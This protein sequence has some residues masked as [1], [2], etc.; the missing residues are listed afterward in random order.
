MFRV[1]LSHGRATV[2]VV[3]VLAADAIGADAVMLVLVVVDVF[4]VAGALVVVLVLVVGVVV[5]NGAVDAVLVGV[6][7]HAVVYV[8]V[9]VVPEVVFVVV[10]L[11]RVV[12][13]RG[14]TVVGVVVLLVH[15]LIVPT[16]GC[17]LD[18]LKVRGPVLAGYLR[19]L[20][21]PRRCNGC[22]ARRPRCPFTWQPFRVELVVGVVV[23]VQLVRVPLSH[24]RVLGRVQLLHGRVVFRV[25][26]SHGRAAVVYR[27][28]VGCPAT[29][30]D[31]SR[32]RSRELT[33]SGWL[34]RNDL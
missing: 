16:L 1:Q 23:R 19:I 17:V 18:G 4:V 22:K 11:V 26:L 13:V 33:S 32:A 6:A 31:L 20:R 10:V 2:V 24:G 3:V 21:E 28:A 34:S 8:A 9:R 5:V 30:A 7:V 27:R 29:T 14:V 12:D 25:Q 15:V